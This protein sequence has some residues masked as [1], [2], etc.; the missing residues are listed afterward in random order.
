M[1]PSARRL[2][3]R[4][5]R[6]VVLRRADA[7]IEVSATKPG[8]RTDLGKR[9]DGTQPAPNPR[10]PLY[11]ETS[12]TLAVDFH[13]FR[14]AFNTALAGAGVNVQQAV[15]LAGHSDA[16]THMRYVMQAPAMRA[17]PAAGLPRLPV[18]AASIVTASCGSRPHLGP[19]ASRIVT[20]RDASSGREIKTRMISAR[21]AGLEPAT[22]GLEGRCSIQLSYG[23]V[24]A[25]LARPS[26]P[27]AGLETSHAG[28]R[29][30]PR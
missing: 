4:A 10:D 6:G 20:A 23:R 15:H 2:K 30:W 27:A 11:F 25:V 21:P 1:L 24:A 26:R 19:L 17:I 3:G 18:S 9:A 7:P 14:R 29:G 16:K 13:S 28:R 22:R 5:R 12:T 8:M